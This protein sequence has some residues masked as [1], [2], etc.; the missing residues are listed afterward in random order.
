MSYQKMPVAPA[1]RWET[2]T[3]VFAA[4][5]VCDAA[6]SSVLLRTSVLSA[7]TQA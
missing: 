3:T 2:Y 5:R 1:M 6:L 4:R 7:I